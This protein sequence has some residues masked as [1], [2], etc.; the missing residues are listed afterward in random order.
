MAFAKVCDEQVRLHGY[1]K[2]AVE[3][4]L[5]I[6]IDKNVL[7]EYLKS[8]EME[9]MDIMTTLFDDGEVQRRYWLR[10]KNEGVEQGTQSATVSNIRS[11]MSGTGWSADKVMDMLKIPVADRQRYIALL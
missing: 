5:R 10:V 9:I 2:K 3:E 8:R 7:S 11:F 6:C 1:T 4:I